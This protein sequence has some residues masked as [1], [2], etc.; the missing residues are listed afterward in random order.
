[1]RS[2]LTERQITQVE[3]TI[4]EVVQRDSFRD[5]YGIVT[6][7]PGVALVTA[8]TVIAEIGDF[9]RF[10]DAKAIGRYAGLNPR[11]YASGGKQRIGH[12]AKT[13]SSELR[14]ILQQAAWTAIRYDEHVKRIFLRIAKRAGR[15][16]A[17]VAVA[18]KLLTW[19]HV[20]VIKG[21]PYRTRLAA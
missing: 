14:W 4:S 11:V 1:M 5:V 16:A 10:P 15:K 13:G 21:E 17:A 20:A 12:I 6:S 8:A 7:F 18:R 3:R 2:A 9:K 19:M